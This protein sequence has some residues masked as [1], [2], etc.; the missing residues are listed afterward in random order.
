MRQYSIIIERGGYFLLYNNKSYSIGDNN[1]EEDNSFSIINTSSKILDNIK[2]KPLY[3]VFDG[4]PF[5]DKRGR[6]YPQLKELDTDHLI[7]NR[8]YSYKEL[9]TI[10]NEPY[11]SSNSKNRQLLE[12][13]R[14]FNYRK[15]NT[16]YVIEEIYDKPL[17]Y[18][19]IC[20]S[21][22]YVQDLTD[23]LLSYLDKQNSNTLYLTYSEL[24]SILGLENKNHKKYKDMDKK[25]LSF[26]LDVPV[27][28]IE[29]FLLRLS[30]Y[31]HKIINS[32]LKSMMS[33]GIADS[34]LSYQIL[35]KGAD[36]VCEATNQDV[37][38]IVYIECEALKRSK[39]EKKDLWL[40]NNYEKYFAVLNEVMKEYKPDWLLY[41]QVIKINVPEYIPVTKSNNL[42]RNVNRQVYNYIVSKVVSN[43]ISR[44]EHSAAGQNLEP[45]ISNDIQRQVRELANKM[46]LLY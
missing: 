6:Y 34:Y 27:S 23:I 11:K 18:L 26:I 31:Q 15:N 42:K 3:E 20:N 30:S 32:L 22:M 2:H 46:I 16:K 17:P 1:N 44:I 7:L 25:K 38:D 41:Y 35:Y 40:N 5:A 36:K 8:W 13:S 43:Y 21:S 39:L 12:F 45:N 29:L 37:Q 14:F 28:L 9:C 33:R 19:P 4:L 10:L 24:S